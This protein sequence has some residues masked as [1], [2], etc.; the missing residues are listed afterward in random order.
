[1]TFDSRQQKL[2][3][4]ALRIL[5]DQN[6]TD[7]VAKVR[8]IIGPEQIPNS[9][10]MA[11]VA[12]EKMRSGE[13]P[14]PE[15]LAALTI[16]IRVLRPVLLIKDGAI[17]ELPR[18]PDH[19]LYSTTQ[20]DQWELFQNTAKPFIA[21][22]GRVERGDGSHIGTGFLVADGLLTTNRHVLQH[23]TQ[24]SEVLLPSRPA[25]VCFTREH[26][27]NTRP[28]D[29]AEIIAVAGIH[30]ELDICF[31]RVSKQ[32]RRRLPL[33]AEKIVE[34]MPVAVIGY[35]AADDQNPVFMGPV[36]NGVYGVK[37][38]ALGEVLDGMGATR[39]F[40]D[41]STTQGNSGSPVFSLGSGQV[42]GIHCAGQFMYRNEAV[43]YAAWQR[44]LS[45]L[46]V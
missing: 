38:V 40:H 26:D 28:A 4:K 20:R 41:C 14:S 24:G 1:M 6:V 5:G 16:V 34:G 22:I 21:S 2:K 27:T 29:F 13:V 44:Y 17:P 46:A 32:G 23:L 12:L 7:V 3:D 25:R 30:P 15:E 18:D 37:R 35:P 8:A 9:E 45:D 31:L 19:D 33:S 11:Q 43:P 36:F 42:I 39:F 10:R